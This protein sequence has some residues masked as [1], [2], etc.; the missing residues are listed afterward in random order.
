MTRRELS[1][2]DDG[3]SSDTCSQQLKPSG[4]RRPPGRAFGRC[5]RSSGREQRL[6]PGGRFGPEAPLN[7]HLPVPYLSPLL[8]PPAGDGS[9]SSGLGQKHPWQR[10][11]GDARGD[12][13]AVLRP[14]GEGLRPVPPRAPAAR[15]HPARVLCPVRVASPQHPPQEHQ[16]PRV[17]RDIRCD[18][19]RGRRA[20][21]P[22][23]PS[24]LRDR[25]LISNTGALHTRS[26]V[27]G[28]PV[29]LGTPPPSEARPQ[30]AEQA[31]C[32]CVRAHTPLLETKCRGLQ[33]TKGTAGAPTDVRGARGCQDLPGRV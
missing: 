27:P 2:S 24:P 17:T 16:T 21:G 22:A 1:E 8:F 29:V 15:V 26:C 31:G 18:H 33:P 32:S 20:R 6:A 9:G 23:G 10:R 12:R 4:C 28:P 13:P 14:S 5:P 3:E 11:R 25:L 30:H 19:P 7:R